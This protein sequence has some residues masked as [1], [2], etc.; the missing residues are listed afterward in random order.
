MILVALR[1]RDLSP[2]A[3][4]E[5]RPCED[6]V[7]VAIC[8]TGREP[9]AELDHASTVISDSLPPDLKAAAQY[10]IF[11]IAARAEIE[12]YLISTEEFSPGLCPGYLP[13]DPVDVTSTLL[14]LAS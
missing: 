8:K 3:L 1:K 9:S 5:G 2:C 11:A 6:I 14:C 13:F 4:T 12:L 7:G 10:T